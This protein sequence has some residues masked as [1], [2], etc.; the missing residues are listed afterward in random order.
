MTTAQTVQIAINQS[1]L[2]ANLGSVFSNNTKFLAE[3]LQNARRSGASI[4]SVL[5]AENC[6]T[7]IDNGSGIS[8]F[9]DLLTLAQS[10]WSEDVTSEEAPYGMGFFSALFAAKKVVVSSQGKKITI[11]TDV[12]LLDQKIAIEGSDVINGTVIELYDHEI[13]NVFSLLESY[14]K[15]FP[16][17]VFYS[18]EANLRG[19]TVTYSGELIAKPD[20][21]NESFED[22]DCGKIKYDFEACKNQSSFL[23]YCAYLQGFA[24]AQSQ[25]YWFGPKPTIHL[26]SSFRARMPDRDALIDA[27]ANAKRIEDGIKAFLT[28][29]VLE[30]KEKDPKELFNYFSLIKALDMKEIL[31]DVPYIP[32]WFIGKVDVVEKTSESRDSGWEFDQNRHSNP[33]LYYSQEDL[34][35]QMIVS[36]DPF[37]TNNDQDDYVMALR[38]ALSI[39]ETKI[40]DQNLHDDHWIYAQAV[41]LPDFYDGLSQ[42]VFVEFES[43]KAGKWGHYDLHLV[44]SYKIRVPDL[45]LEVVVTEHHGLAIGGDDNGCGK[46][47]LFLIPKGASASNILCQVSDWYWDDYWHEDAQYEDVRSLAAMM[48]ILEGKDSAEVF[49]SLLTETDNLIRKELKGK[50]FSVEFLDDGQLSVLE[51]V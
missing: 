9:T 36:G 41:E 30:V 11:H 39:S 50:K 21:L 45:E 12:D 19:E 28:K 37:Q 17:D 35:G 5:N 40:L 4:I 42:Y 48:S 18:G 2:I 24:V 29:K 3:L 10:N 38:M 25:E 6:L 32:A 7:I 43:S 14:C 13:K 51:I 26:D 23:T 49:A 22:F 20:T 46:N 34:K 8:S 16:V 15:G 47:N 31:N 33:V 1:R 27:K 44:P